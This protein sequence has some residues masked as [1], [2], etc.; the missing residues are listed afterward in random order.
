MMA[1][2]ES[3][4]LIVD[5]DIHNLKYLEA[6]L[7]TGGY[8]TKTASDG[9]QA[10]ETVGS[11]KPDLIL[12]DLIMPGIDGFE[13]AR[14]LKLD[15]ATKNIPIIMI[16]SLDDR[17]SKIRALEVGA[18][19]FLTKPVDRAELWVRVRNL[20]RL[21]EYTNFL[22]NHTQILEGQIKQRTAQ[23][24]SS[25]RETIQTMNRAAAYRDE[26]TGAHVKRISYYCVELAETMGMSADFCERIFY[27]S[28]MHDVGKIG[29]PDA[30]L[31]K[32]GSFQADEWEIMKSHSALGAKM[33]ESGES[34]YLSMGREIAM[35]HHER[36]DGSGYPHGLAGENIPLAARIMQIAD[37]YDALRS[38]RPYK[39]AYTQ[40]RALEI[41]LNGDGRVMPGHFDPQVLDAFRISSRRLLEIYDTEFEHFGH[42]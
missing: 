15:S 8:L 27:A 24:T 28:P 17:D 1:D 20:L 18:E 40:T 13:V 35:W 14:R 21:R 29:I 19:E 41:I 2:T 37:V 5:D 6:V 39:T 34:P 7:S 36:W 11:F 9:E 38:K 33:L 16:T 32:P 3:R 25:Y 12:L 23:L 26:E 4:I 31:Q 22:A 10:L 42:V 30:I